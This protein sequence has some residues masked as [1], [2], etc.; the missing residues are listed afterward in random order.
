LLCD[1]DPFQAQMVQDHIHALAKRSRH[2]VFTLSFRGA[3]PVALD[4]SRFD[5]IVIHYSLFIYEERYLAADTRQ[6]LA[7]FGGLKAVF[8]HD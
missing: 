4:L 2:T 1:Y 5:A 8:L 7:A 3:L 6:R